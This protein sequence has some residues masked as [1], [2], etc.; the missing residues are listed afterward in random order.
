MLSVIDTSL[1]L[2][3]GSRCGESRYSG[4]ASHER[5]WLIKC[6]KMHGSFDVLQMLL[7]RQLTAY[8]AEK[9]QVRCLNV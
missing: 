7:A 3:A 2:V 8:L 9:Y 5:Y 6:Y 4:I 1:P